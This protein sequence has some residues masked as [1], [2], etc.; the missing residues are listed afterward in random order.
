MLQNLL[1]IQVEGLAALAKISS[2]GHVSRHW[3]SVSQL[4]AL[5]RESRELPNRVVP[6]IPSG[7]G[8]FT[9]EAV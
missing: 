4:A 8:I 5:T 3:S 1:D 9:I 7:D 6:A 2:A